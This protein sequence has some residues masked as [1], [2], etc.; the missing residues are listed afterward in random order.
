MKLV[1]EIG[2]FQRIS[3]FRLTKF[4]YAPH[5]AER[6]FI[7]ILLLYGHDCPKTGTVTGSHYLYVKF[8]QGLQGSGKPPL[9]DI[10]Q[11]GPAN[12]SIDLTFSR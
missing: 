1:F 12:H 8:L 3:A 4:K 11:M 2:T 9:G 10:H 5:L 7:G 6:E